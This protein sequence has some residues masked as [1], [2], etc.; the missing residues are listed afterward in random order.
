MTALEKIKVQK[1]LKHCNFAT[2]Y[3][4]FPAMI[5][6]F[7]MLFPAYIAPSAGLFAY[8]LFCFIFSIFTHWL[9]VSTR[10]RWRTVLAHANEL[11]RRSRIRD[12]NPNKG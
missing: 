2:R 8:V 3:I 1:Y 5:V 4:S 7:V 12:L 9:N 6:S 10:N 11:E